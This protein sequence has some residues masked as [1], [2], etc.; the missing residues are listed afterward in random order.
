[1][2]TIEQERDIYKYALETIAS[3]DDGNLSTRAFGLLAL[4]IEVAQRALQQAD[5]SYPIRRAK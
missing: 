3:F 5:G 2:C 4:A 1:M